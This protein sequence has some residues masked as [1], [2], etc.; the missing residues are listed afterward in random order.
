MIKKTEEVK[1]DAGRVVKPVYTMGSSTPVAIYTGTDIIVYK[2]AAGNLKKYMCDGGD[3]N[4]LEVMTTFQGISYMINLESED[5]FPVEGTIVS[6]VFDKSIFYQLKDEFDLLL[7]AKNE[8][9]KGSRMGIGGIQVMFM[10]SGVSIDDTS[11]E[12]EYTYKARTFIPW[13]EIG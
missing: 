2:I 8:H 12:E 6:V 5:N 4:E 11:N 3:I 9:G 7:I 1:N 13:E 10:G